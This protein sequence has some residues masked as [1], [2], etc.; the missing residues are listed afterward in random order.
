MI[1]A[2]GDLAKTKTITLKKQ[3]RIIKTLTGREQNNPDS[4]KFRFW[5]KAK[6]FTIDKPDDFKAVPSLVA[7]N[8]EEENENNSLYIPNQTKV[9]H[10][11]FFSNFPFMVLLY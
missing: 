7:Y 5:V 4:S 6:G 3:A 1:K 9:S 10:V 8:M 11:P 2:Y